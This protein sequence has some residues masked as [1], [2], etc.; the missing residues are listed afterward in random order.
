MI[1]RSTLRLALL[2][3]LTLVFVAP[4]AW[5]QSG[6]CEIHDV[7]DAA[8]DNTG[9]DLDPV[10][11]LNQ[12]DLTT[13]CIAED[14]ASIL[15]IVNTSA[16][17]TENAARALTFT[18]LFTSNGTTYSAVYDMATTTVTPAF[19]GA[20]ASATGSTITLSLPRM[21]VGALLSD[22]F[23][24]SHGEFVTATAVTE[25]DDRAPDGEATVF[26]SDAP[27]RVGSRA[28]PTL[29]SDGDGE[30][31]RNELAAGTNP[32]ALDTDFDGL[33][34]GATVEVETGST[35][36]QNYTSAGIL[37]LRDDGTLIQFAGEKQ[38]GTNASRPDTDGDGLLDGANVTAA[39]GSQAATTF[40]QFGLSPYLNDVYLGEFAFG[41]DPR[42][43]DSDEDGLGD[44]EEVSGSDTH[45]GN[46]AF[47]PGQ[48]GST[49]P[50]DP[51][52]DDDQLLDGE[53]QEGFATIEGAEV[54][55]LPTDP[56]GKD[57]DHDGLTDYE[58]LRGIQENADGSQTT[59]PPT[60]PTVADS[61]GDSFDDGLE[62]AAGSDPTDANSVPKEG[63]DDAPGGAEA[64]YLWLSTVA[65]LVVG[66]LCVVGIL[67]RWG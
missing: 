25:S 60:D 4:S 66:L 13:G 28:P 17:P 37:V 34:D 64:S 20:T 54:G 48:D 63:G 9:N 6:T 33:L 19:A 3:L 52:T 31:D 22:V 11:G 56:N 39:P 67:V 36:A 29:D 50:N 45:Y 16:A 58:E 59:F 10:T 53:E 14:A 32:Y 12:I 62:V 26:P 21:T 38:F 55:F 15:I 27:Y 18:F 44:G 42:T 65:M 49:D 40:E 46:T 57:T 43:S 24:E 1:L 2:A 47:F 5:G 41:A 61:D 8:G 51:D 23:I 30:T 7:T 35:E